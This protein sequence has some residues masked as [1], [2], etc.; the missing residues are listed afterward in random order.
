MTLIASCHTYTVFINR[1]RY[2]D[3]FRYKCL[4]CKMDRKGHD[5][6]ILQLLSNVIIWIWS[7]LKNR[8]MRS[9]HFSWISFHHSQLQTTYRL[10]LAGIFQIDQIISSSFN[11]HWSLLELFATVKYS[12]TITIF[13]SKQRTDE[14]FNIVTFC[15]NFFLLMYLCIF[16]LK[17]RDFTAAVITELFFFSISDVLWLFLR[18]FSDLIRN[19]VPLAPTPF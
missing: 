14:W 9:K 4:F 8:A 11:I 6:V 17:I 7:T 12:F 5:P 18:P 1:S 13:F 10:Y 15:G 3:T 2:K 19:V 16:S